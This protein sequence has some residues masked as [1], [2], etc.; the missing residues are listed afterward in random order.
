MQKLSLEERI[1]KLEDREAILNLTFQYALNINLGADRS[2]INTKT[3]RNIF[4]KNAIWECQAM[5]IR[6]EG[7]DNIISSIISETKSVLFSMHSYSNPVITISRVNAHAHFLFWVT[8]KIKTNSI[9]QVFMSQDLQYVKTKNG[10]RICNVQLYYGDH[11][12]SVSEQ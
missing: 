12:K 6:E 4:T 11:I 8:S 3:L 5:N 1:Q 10:W 7:I 9:N 2:H